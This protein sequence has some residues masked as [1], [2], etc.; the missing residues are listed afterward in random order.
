[1]RSLKWIFA[2]TI[3]LLL[4][5]TIFAQENVFYYQ[6]LTPHGEEGQIQYVV[7]SLDTCFHV[8]SSLITTH[9]T[10]R[11]NSE[12]FTSHNWEPKLSYKWIQT[13]RGEVVLESRYYEN[14][15]T[16]QLQAPWGEKMTRLHFSPPVF[17][18]E[19]VPLLLSALLEGKTKE[20][21]ISIFISVS[22]MVWKGKFRSVEENGEEITFRFTLAGE[23]MFFRYR[24]NDLMPQEMHFP[25]RG[26]TLL[27]Q[28][29]THGE[30]QALSL[31]RRKE[32]D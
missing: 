14:T 22:G 26:Y 16:L 27:L 12:F 31:D 30:N 7:E 8:V 2:L 4:S 3:P 10:S 17:D 11:K 23:V 32:E 20:G 19:E 1:M 28:D 29:V 18:V 6:I 5:C 21:I 24:K 15:I 25:H 9:G 13:P